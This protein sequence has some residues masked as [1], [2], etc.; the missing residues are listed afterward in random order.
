[1]SRLNYHHLY[2][3][4]QVAKSP[5]LT[6]AAEQLHISQSALSAQIK[7]LESSLDVA[8]FVRQGRKLVLTDVG[9]RVLAYAQDIFNT[10]EE[11]ENFLQKDT[12]AQGQHITLGVQSNLSR[13]FIESFIEPLLQSEHV[14]FSLSSRGITDLLN[15]L[16]NHELDLALTNRPILSESKDTSWQNQLVARQAV[17]IIGPYG[18][19]PDLPFPEGYRDKKWIVPGKNTDI[20]SAFE[21][22]C[23]THQYQPDIKAEV[24]DMA[25]LRL[26]AR[27]SGYL[28]VLPT[29]VVK[30]EIQSQQLQD[31]E[32][33]PQAFESFYA[34][35]VPRKFAVQ[36]VLDL[37]KTAMTTYDVKL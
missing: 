3:F 24:D 25:M 5:S 6:E 32:S 2:Y 15:G 29:V 31:Y 4:W 30:D 35:T 27:D 1:M 34:I 16:V 8:L 14:S 9:R 17:A 12:V 22:F 11:L 18:Q 37:I 21:S 28:S 20:R 19:K 26:L 10:G 36:S 23:A 7:Q 33:I 13:N